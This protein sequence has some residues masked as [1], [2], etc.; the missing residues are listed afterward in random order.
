MPAMP[1]P[2]A[3]LASQPK[4]VV[5]GTV[6]ML[7][8]TPTML[9]LLS[10]LQTAALNSSY[11]GEE[12]ERVAFALNENEVLVGTFEQVGFADGDEIKAV[13]SPQANGN[14]LAHAAV[15]VSDGLLWMPYNVD[16][17][18]KDQAKR[19]LR[20]VSVFA[21]LLL[22][23]VAVMGVATDMSWADCGLALLAGAGVLAVMAFWGRNDGMTEARYAESIFAKLGFKQPSEVDLSPYSLSKEIEYLGQRAGYVFRLRKALA[24]HG[25]LSPAKPEPAA[26]AP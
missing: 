8:K 19:N 15:R 18:C 2:Y 11:D 14:L 12:A 1:H 22:I 13:V 17:G 24:A 7:K 16:R 26:P 9:N 21:V 3:D 5:G 4:H 25:S 23:A 6:S 20:F 10:H